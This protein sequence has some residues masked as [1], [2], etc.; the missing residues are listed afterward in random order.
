LLRLNASMALVMPVCRFVDPSWPISSWITLV[1]QYVV[2]DWFI[3]AVRAKTDFLPRA[4]EWKTSIP[5]T[6]V[7]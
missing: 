7:G 1:D 6:I 3:E 2:A 5:Q 4:V